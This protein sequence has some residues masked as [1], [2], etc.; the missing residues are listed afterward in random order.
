MPDCRLVSVGD[1]F[2]KGKFD[3]FHSCFEKVVNFR[4]ENM[5]VSVVSPLIGAG[6]FNIVVDG[7]K[8]DSIREISVTD[9]KICINNDLELPYSACDIFRSARDFTDIDRQQV[10]SRYAEL[11]GF[12]TRNLNSSLQF[13]LTGDAAPQ[14][15]TAFDKEVQSQFKLAY[16]HLLNGDIESTV[17]GFKGRG[18]GLTPAGDD[19]LAGLLLGTYFTDIHSAQTCS[20]IRNT[21]YHNAL[22]SNPLSNSMLTQAYN[23]WLNERWS[24][25]I[26]A[27]NH[28]KADLSGEIGQITAVGASSGTDA[29]TGFLCAWKIGKKDVNP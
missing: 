7:I 12:V 11:L 25:F 3:A 5:V 8:P 26:T 17:Q 9:D 1:R 10:T 19:Y 24:D 13:I 4:Y 27:V 20:D 18:Y 21:V 29:L 6:P 23:L 14:P 2:P 22:G 15:E 28:G 16:T